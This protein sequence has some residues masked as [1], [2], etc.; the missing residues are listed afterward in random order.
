MHNPYPEDE[1]GV[2][3]KILEPTSLSLP[4][5]IPSQPQLP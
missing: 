2:E 4:S 5:W 3:I 1:D